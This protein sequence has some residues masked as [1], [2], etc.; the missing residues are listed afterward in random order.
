MVMEVVPAP[1]EAEP[2]ADVDEERAA[3]ESR[4]GP[5]ALSAVVV[6]L[7]AVMT[8]SVVTLFFGAFAFG[9][10]G[11]QE[12]RSQHQLYAQFRGLLDP[13]SPIAPDIGGVIPDGSPVALLD[14]PAA[15]IHNLVVVE[16][17]SA[18]DLLNGP[19][20][21]ADSPLPGQAGES[22][23]LGKSTTAG[24]PFEHLTQ[25]RRGDVVTVRTGQGRFRFTVQGQLVAGDRPPPTSTQGGLLT[26]VT[27]AGSGPLGHLAPNRVV[28]VDARL[29]GK[30]VTAPKGRP[31]T[32]PAAQIQGHNDSGAWLFAGLWLV[33]LA[34]TAVACWRLWSRWGVM[35]TWLVGAPLAFGVLWGF[36]TEAMRLLPNVY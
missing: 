31:T 24:A 32:V 35:Q 17:T 26:L 14:A 36:S 27:S 12:Q 30:A 13:A 28:Y 3:P 7:A 20:H 10:G 5:P 16:G 29:D 1:D 19:G 9:F 15:G 34:A 2:A 23:L 6:I 11:L 33:G 8:L 22:F 18:G 25:L 4:T 21:L